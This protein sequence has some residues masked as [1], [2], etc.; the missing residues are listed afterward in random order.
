MFVPFQ[1]WFGGDEG[2]GFIHSTPVPALAAHLPLA[3]PPLLLPFPQ[4]PTL[5]LAL[6]HHLALWYDPTDHLTPQHRRWRWRW[7]LAL[8]TGAGHWRW[9]SALTRLAL[10]AHGRWWC[11]RIDGWLRIGCPVQY[12]Y[13]SSPVYSLSFI[14]LTP[15]S[16]LTSPSFAFFC[17]YY[18][19]HSSKRCFLSDQQDSILVRQ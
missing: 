16:L 12:F 18:S 17:Q 19:I 4:P 14:L 5:P 15:P 10:D 8:G 7:V 13:L 1:Y 3:P 9:A 11:L 6:A 2:L